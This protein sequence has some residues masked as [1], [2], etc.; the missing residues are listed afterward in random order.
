ML[1]KKACSGIAFDALTRTHHSR[2]T[3]VF[4]DEFPHRLERFSEVTGLSRVELAHRLGT[5]RLTI[6]WWRA[7]ARS[8]SQDLTVMKS[9]EAADLLQE[10]ESLRTLLSKLSEASRRVSE[11]LDLSIVLQEVIDNACSL[12]GARY[13]ALLATG[14]RRDP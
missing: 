9:T 4:P 8:N 10:I 5:H 1:P 3:C 2:V 13:G 14:V 11:N 7:G 12:T 6:R